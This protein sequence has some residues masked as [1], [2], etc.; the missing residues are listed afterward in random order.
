MRE[1]DLKLTHSFLS[2]L[3]FFSGDFCAAG[4]G[5]GFFVTAFLS[6]STGA[7]AAGDGTTVTGTADGEGDGDGNGAVVDC[8]AECAPFSPGSD[9]INASNMKA[10]A[11][12]IVIFARMFAVPR[13]PKAVLET[14]LVKSAPASALPGC[15]R[16][17]TM[18]TAQAAI[19]NP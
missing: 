9:N 10:T 3:F 12:P 17:T 14:L 2:Y 19:N 16:M 11:A 8:N 6:V 15:N 4:D 1:T 5:S 18:S 7:V 13:G